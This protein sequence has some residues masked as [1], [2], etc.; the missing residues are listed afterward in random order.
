MPTGAAA[1]ERPEVSAVIPTLNEEENVEG[2]AK[3][4]ADSL[5]R[6][7]VTY[8]I[9]FIDNGS[10]D[11]TVR[12]VKGLCSSDRRIRLIVNTRNFGQMRSPTHGIYQATATGAV[13]GVC[14]DFQD[15]PEM[16]VE[17]IQRWQAG[18]M[19][20]LGVRASEQVGLLTR[21]IRDLGY[22]FFSRFGDYQVIPG[23]TG[24]G[25]YDRRVVETLK[26]WRD[27][28]PFF[29][30]M[31]VESGYPLSTIPYHRP[32]RAGGKTKNNFFT[33]FGFALSSL[34]ASSKGLLR[35]PLPTALVASFA[36]GLT[37]IWAAISAIAGRNGGPAFAWGMA[38]AAFAVISLFIGLLGEQLRLVA[39]MSRGVPLVIEKERVN[40]PDA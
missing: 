16:L 25:L 22:G 5:H 12:L 29:R 26:R 7:G 38:E 37:L 32:P 17:F 24:F 18:A 34:A 28:E 31:L 13:I 9:I 35:L 3:A 6:A 27:P 30:G 11:D 23:A 2:I 1:C 39:E 10:T 40:F 8:E 36:A 21:A 20:V 15:P 33:L 19:I 4:V 14:A